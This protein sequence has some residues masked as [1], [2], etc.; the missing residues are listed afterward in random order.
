MMEPYIN[1]FAEHSAEQAESQD[2][3]AHEGSLGERYFVARTE[4]G[5]CV[6]NYEPGEESYLGGPFLTWDGAGAFVSAHKRRHLLSVLL[7]GS[8]ALVVVT[9]AATLIRHFVG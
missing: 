8:A 4:T 5:V 1:T 9:L 7:V 6:V 2:L 3:S